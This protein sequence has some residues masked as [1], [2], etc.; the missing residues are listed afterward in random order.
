MP[1]DAP[2][3]RPQAVIDVEINLTECAIVV[4]NRLMRVALEERRGLLADGWPTGHALCAAL[5]AVAER[6]ASEGDHQRRALVRL[7]K[8]RDRG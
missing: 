7:L 6:W 2:T 5:D 8:E 1:A 3:T 4:C